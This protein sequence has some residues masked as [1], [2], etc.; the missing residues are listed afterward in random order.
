[1]GMR[2]ICGTSL[3]GAQTIGSVAMFVRPW[4]RDR[5]RPLTKCITGYEDSEANCRCHVAHMEFRRDVGDPG[6]INGRFNV[7]GECQKTC[8]EHHPSLLSARSVFRIL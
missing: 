4:K 1:M 7:N 5:K 8:L 3:K 6:S 2:P